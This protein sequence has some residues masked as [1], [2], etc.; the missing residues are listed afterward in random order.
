MIIENGTIEIKYKTVKGIDAETGFPA[1]SEDITWG[2][3]IPCQWQTTRYSNLGQS[4]A[5]NVTVAHY[6][7]LIE[8][9]KAFTGEQIRLRDNYGNVL[10]EF[11][12]IQVEI[13]SAVCQLRITV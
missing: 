4:E 12:V 1:V 9:E 6:S 11:S 2:G 10:G 13:L 8:S 7:I 5:G 3:P